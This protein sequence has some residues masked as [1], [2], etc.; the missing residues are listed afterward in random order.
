MFH[1]FPDGAFCSGRKRTVQESKALQL[2]KQEKE[3]KRGEVFSGAHRRKKRRERG[4]KN[5]G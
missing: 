3:K 4:G 2:K 5:R 1:F